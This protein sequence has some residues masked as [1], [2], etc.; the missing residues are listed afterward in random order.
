MSAL[1]LLPASLALWLQACLDVMPVERL[2][3]H[4]HDTYGQALANILAA[5]GL[6]IRVVDTAVA[7]LGGCPFAKGATGQWICIMYLLIGCKD[8]VACRSSAPSNE[9]DAVSNVLSIWKLPCSCLLQRHFQRSPVT[10]TCRHAA[11]L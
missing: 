4:M 3:A 5:L 6:G 10:K 2:A 7:G 11:V 1:L 9:V 8:C